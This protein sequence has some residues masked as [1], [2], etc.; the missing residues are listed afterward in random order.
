MR[1]TIRKLVVLAIGIVTLLLIAACGG[2]TKA[3]TVAK[4][5]RG[6]TEAGALNAL[7]AYGKKLAGEGELSGA[8]LISKDDRVLFR[9]AYGL[10]DRARRTPNTVVTRFRIGSMNKMFTAVAILQLVE[11]G[12]VNLTAAAGHIPPRLPQ[13]GG[14]D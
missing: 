1:L 11:A 5:H 4:T 8:V 14:R 2:G 7:S 12:K 6:M 3:F 13:P 9:H 10:A